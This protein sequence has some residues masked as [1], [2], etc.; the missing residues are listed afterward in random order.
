[1]DEHQQSYKKKKNACKIAATAANK[2]NRSPC[3]PHN[4]WEGIK[5]IKQINEAIQID[6]EDFTMKHK[7]AMVI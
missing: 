6:D 1:L 3:F 4:G 5:K 7:W 2:K